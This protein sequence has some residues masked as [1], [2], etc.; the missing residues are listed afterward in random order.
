[1]MLEFELL[2]TCRSMALGQ[3]PQLSELLVIVPV[4]DPYAS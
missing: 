3:G 1:M 2:A 4:V